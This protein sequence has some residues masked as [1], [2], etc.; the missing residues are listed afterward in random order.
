M[1]PE[2]PPDD[3]IPSTE[4]A[5]ICRCHLK[6]LLRWERQGKLA[7]WERQGRVFYSKAQCEQM[8]K[9]RKIGNRP[10]HR[11]GVQAQAR[12]TAEI[13]AG[14]GLDEPRDGQAR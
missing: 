10:N 9:R 11:A 8:F 4:A 12:R 7:G 6:T 5:R 2:R 14:A 1:S 3:L 13:L